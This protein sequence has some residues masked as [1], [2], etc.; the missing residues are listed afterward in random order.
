MEDLLDLIT[1]PKVDGVVLTERTNEKHPSLEGTLCLSG[2]QL[3]L[4]A[5]Q[6]LKK[7]FWLLYRNIDV[8]E[9]KTNN[10]SPGGCIILKCKDFRILQLDIASTDDLINITASI[11]KLSSLGNNN[12]IKRRQIIII[13]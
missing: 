2:H 9:K 11:E 3:L 4:S 6:E 13:N 5:R 8:I 10:Q 7:D 1:V 12:N